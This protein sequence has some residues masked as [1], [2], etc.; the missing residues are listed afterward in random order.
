MSHA[1]SFVKDHPLQA[2][3]GM[4]AAPAR[5][6]KKHPWEA[7]G[8]AAA[9]MTGGAAAGVFGAGALGAGE[10]AA[11]GAGLLG[12]ETGGPALLG[13]GAG[14]AS[15]GADAVTAMTAGSPSLLGAGADGISLGAD[16]SSGSGFKMPGMNAFGKKLLM[17]Q[18]FG[19]LNQQPQRPPMGGGMPQSQAPI[20]NTVLYPQNQRM[21]VG[22]NMNIP[23]EILNNPKLLQAY[24]A[25]MGAQ[26]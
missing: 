19:L 26:A 4:F 6:A 20:Q 1:T 11:G 18:G 21:A 25:Q 10:A 24:L 16:A 12:A 14:G 7:A 9:A 13:A 22:G 2:A 8:I 17:Q 15:L 23:P 5:W 3:T